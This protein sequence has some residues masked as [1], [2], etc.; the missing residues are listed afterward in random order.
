M[1]IAARQQRR[2]PVRGQP[3]IG[4]AIGRAL[5]AQAGDQQCLT[6]IV[7]V[8]IDAERGTHRAA[9]TISSNKQTRLQGLFAVIVGNSDQPLPV[10]YLLGGNEARRAIAGQRAELQQAGFQCIAEI[11]GDDHPAEFLAAMLGR[12]QL[13]TPEIPGTA[14]VDALDAAGRIT[15][16]RHH[17]QGGQG[18]DR[19]LGETEV[20]LIEHGGQRTGRA[21]LQHSHIQAQA[22]ERDGEA[23]ANQSAPDN[24]DVVAAWRG[25]SGLWHCAMLTA[26]LSPDR[27]RI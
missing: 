12:I 9:R 14:D 17:A 26:P 23:G 22:V 1:A 4:G 3:L 20:A 19:G 8:G 13:D 6:V 18:V 27:I 24:Q 11:A 7:F 21:G 10:P 2:W 25:G 15:Q 5:A 16:Q